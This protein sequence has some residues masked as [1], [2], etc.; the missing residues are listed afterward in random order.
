MAFRLMLEGA[1]LE[2]NT[3]TDAKLHIYA[4]DGKTLT[5]E[6]SE[7]DG[8]TREFRYFFECMGSG[9]APTVVTPSSSL[10]ALA[11]VERELACVGSAHPSRRGRRFERLSG[12]CGVGQ[13]VLR[14]H[15]QAVSCPA[16]PS[17]TRSRSA[18]ANAWRCD[19]R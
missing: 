5:P 7:E 11:L 18:C 8:Y 13:Q 10:E 4:A 16:R 12:S 2:F 15:S 14:S 19:T 17:C 1:T 9:Q 6:L 3:L